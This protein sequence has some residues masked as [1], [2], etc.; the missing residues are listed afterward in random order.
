MSAW[1]YFVKV[2]FDNGGGPFTTRQVE[3]MMDNQELRPSTVNTPVGL[4]IVTDINPGRHG[5][6]RILKWQLTLLG[7]DFMVGRLLLGYDKKRGMFFGHFVRHSWLSP[8]PRCNQSSMESPAQFQPPVFREFVDISTRCF[9]GHRVEGK[10][11]S[12]GV[13][14]TDLKKAQTAI[15][16]EQAQHTAPSTVVPTIIPMAVCEG[17]TDQQDELSE[18]EY[19]G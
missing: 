12:H 3:D 13:V 7:E 5:N 14:K 10:T 15:L 9:T 1:R 6:T 16:L 17:A 4:G 2:I 11:A 8:L 18:G 19:P